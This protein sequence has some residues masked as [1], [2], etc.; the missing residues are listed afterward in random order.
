MTYIYPFRAK[1][2]FEKD[3]SRQ[4]FVQQVST[5]EDNHQQLENDVNIL[6]SDVT[7]LKGDNVILKDD[8]VILKDDNVKLN[9]DNATLKDEVIVLKR[10]LHAL[11]GRQAITVYEERQLKE[12]K[13]SPRIWNQGHVCFANADAA[14]QMKTMSLENIVKYEQMMKDL[15]CNDGNYLD[16]SKFLVET[17]R[18]AKQFG[19]EA[20][21]FGN[22]SK[23]EALEAIEDTFDVDEDDED[24]DDENDEKRDKQLRIK[25]C[26]IRFIDIADKT[27]GD[28][29]LLETPKDYKKRMAKANKV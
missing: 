22:V 26:L 16:F 2:A 7:V 27:K 6:K 11:I 12:L 28:M 3:A 25:S 17:A 5:L 14:Y 4:Q 10:N 8:N 29:Y 18:I 20:A 19:N 9:G 13:Q 21:H 1:G 15:G 23:T 24:E